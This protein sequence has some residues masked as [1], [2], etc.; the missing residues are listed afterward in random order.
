MGH[1]LDSIRRAFRPRVVALSMVVMMAAACAED[2]RTGPSTGTGTVREP[3]LALAGTHPG[4]V[5]PSPPLN[6]SQ[7]NWVHPGMVNTATPSGVLTFLS[8]LKAKRGRVLIKL[9]GPED[10]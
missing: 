6:L 4:V 8:Q 3:D 5:F 7:I 9:A 1:D 2:D 10:T